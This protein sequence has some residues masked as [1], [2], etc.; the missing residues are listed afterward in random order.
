MKKIGRPLLWLECRHHTSE[1]VLKSAWGV[2][3]EDSNGPN[4]EEFAPF[5]SVWK[6]LDKSSFITLEIL[7]GL[8]SELR[9]KTIS[10]LKDLLSQPNKNQQLPRDDYEELAK[11]TLLVL[12]V[13]DIPGG[14]SWRKPGAH[15]KARFMAYVIYCI[16]MFLFHDMKIDS[17]KMEQDGIDLDLDMTE[18]Y[19][20]GLERMVKFSC[21]VYVP[22]FLSSSIGS[23]APNNDLEFLKTLYKYMLIDPALANAALTTFKRHLHY[24]SGQKILFSLFS[25]KIDSDKK[26]RIAARVLTF[27]KPDSH[28]CKKPVVVCPKENSELE[29]LVTSESWFLF[30]ILGTDSDWLE[31]SPELWPEYESYVEMRK[32]VRTLKVVNDGSERGVKLIQDFSNSITSNTVTRK[33]LLKAVQASRENDPTMKKSDLNKKKVI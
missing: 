13:T 9:E 23:S 29:D 27:P 1:L 10:F 16:K 31:K 19:V 32:F 30:S 8:E 15:H 5:Q 14:F 20:E 22:Y 2:L 3:F 24:L 12:G 28:E 21:L 17:M 33:Y 6:Y 25:N 26:S 18:D 7:P 11:L 4:N